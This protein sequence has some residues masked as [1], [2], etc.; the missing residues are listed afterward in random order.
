[1]GAVMVRVSKSAEAAAFW[2]FSLRCYGRAGVASACL[3]LQDRRGLDVNML[4]FCCHA[5][6]AHGF[7]MSVKEILAAESRV[8]TWQ[9]RIVQPLRAARRAMPAALDGVSG[10]MIEG[11]K[12]R[13]TDAER[14]AEEAEQACLAAI[15]AGR[16]DH[17]PAIEG[18]ARGIA[19]HN[20]RAYLSGRGHALVP[21][22][23]ESLNA[24]LDGCFPPG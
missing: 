18:V 3:D 7:A 21:A 9:V 4:L 19:G 5:A 15:L 8:A 23:E 2:D 22:D 11:I 16:G 20:L 1:M 17:P 6:A 10:S 24:I 13:I 12:A 14:A